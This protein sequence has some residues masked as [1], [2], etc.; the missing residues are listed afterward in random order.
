MAELVFPS[1]SC[2]HLGPPPVFQ[3]Q[4]EEELRVAVHLP[5]IC[6]GHITAWLP[7][8]SKVPT[9]LT[10]KAQ[11]KIQVPPPSRPGSQGLLW[12]FFEGGQRS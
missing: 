10:A 7:M 4:E 8:C 11:Y 3:R 5:S 12:V 6:S 1:P 2:L 9:A